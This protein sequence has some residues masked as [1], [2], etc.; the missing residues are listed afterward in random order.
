[1]TA[2]DARVEWARSE[3]TRLRSAALSNSGVQFNQVLEYG[4]PTLH[5]FERVAPA[6]SFHIIAKTQVGAGFNAPTI[7]ER[8][9][10]LL[11]EWATYVES[12]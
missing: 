6:S 12:G 2:Y 3:A 7:M 4:A 11:E 1:M 10:R 8:L 5:F 9:A